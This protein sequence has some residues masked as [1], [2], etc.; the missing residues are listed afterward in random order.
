M[1]DEAKKVYILCKDDITDDQ[2]TFID[3]SFNSDY[4]L[5]TKVAITKIR[6]LQ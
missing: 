3:K 4:I 2:I 6:N 5:I 1:S